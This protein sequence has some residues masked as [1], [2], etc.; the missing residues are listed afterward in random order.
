M[1][2]GDDSSLRELIPIQDQWSKM[3]VA[4]LGFYHFEFLG[5]FS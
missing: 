1:F 4:I 5:I 2:S 3:Q